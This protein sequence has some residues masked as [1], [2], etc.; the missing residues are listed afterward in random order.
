M[1]PG[2]NLQMDGVLKMGGA[3]V[4]AIPRVVFGAHSASISPLNT[5]LQP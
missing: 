2:I 5:I 3:V 4:Q 1:N